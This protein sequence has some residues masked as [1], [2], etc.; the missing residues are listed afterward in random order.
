MAEAPAYPLWFTAAALHPLF[1]L[2]VGDVVRYNPLTSPSIVVVRY[3]PPNHG[4]LLD[5]IE[6]GVL[7]P[8][9]ADPSVVPLYR[10][11]AGP[12]R[13]PARSAGP[14]RVLAFPEDRRGA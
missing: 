1:G 7:T 6:R 4:A 9:V 2:W 13:W 5:A 11:E 8:V 12:P 10:G 14:P 3:L